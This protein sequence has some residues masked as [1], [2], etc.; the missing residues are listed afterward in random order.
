MFVV[1]NVVYISLCELIICSIRREALLLNLSSTTTKLF[2]RQIW[3]LIMVDCVSASFSL[4]KKNT[5]TDY[6]SC[7]LSKNKR[8]KFKSNIKVRSFS[9]DVWHIF[10][11]L[12]CV[13][14]SKDCNHWRNFTILLNNGNEILK[15]FI[16]FS[17]VFIVFSLAAYWRSIPILYFSRH[18]LKSVYICSWNH[19]RNR[20][21]ARFP[22]VYQ[23]TKTYLQIFIKIKRKVGKRAR[24]INQLII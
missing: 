3:R 5:G 1:E 18:M 19:K 20:Y 8:I 12:S 22:I 14:N 13:T 23:L 2:T 9:Q 17:N 16:I 15:V 4:I 7:R 10:W 21:I 24:S 11:T 6:E